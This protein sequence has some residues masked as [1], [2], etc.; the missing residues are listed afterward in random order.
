MF[1]Q[2]NYIGVRPAVETISVYLEHFE[3]FFAVSAI[4]EGSSLHEPLLGEQNYSLFRNLFAP[5][6]PDEKIYLVEKL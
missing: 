4:D 2:W 1:N 3:M 6:N 5:E